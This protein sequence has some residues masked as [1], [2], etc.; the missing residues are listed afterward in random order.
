MGITLWAE[1]L[2]V[3]SQRLTKPSTIPMLKFFTAAATV[4]LLSGTPGFAATCNTPNSIVSYRNFSSGGFEFVEFKFKKPATPDFT[5]SAAS[6]PFSNTADQV[7]PVAGSLHTKIVF[8]G[9]DWMC[10]VQRF[11]TTPK[12]AIKAVKLIEQ[13]EGQLEFVIGRSA[14][15]HYYSTRSISAGAYQLVRLKFRR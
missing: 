11:I 10:T 2:V 5:V 9:V 3:R 13:F 4:L 1:W 15:S 8:R 12:P 7:I 6:P 14:A